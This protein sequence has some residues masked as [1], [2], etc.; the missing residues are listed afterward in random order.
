MK[1]KHAI[2]WQCNSFILESFFMDLVDYIVNE[3]CALKNDHEAQRMAAYMK[4]TM[5]FYGVRAPQR[6]TI[7]KDAVCRFPIESYDRYIAVITQLWKH[8]HREVKYVAIDIARAYP[9]YICAASLPFYKRMI[10]EGAWWDF[11]DDIAINLVGKALLHDP[12]ELW[13]ILDT[14]IDDTRLWVRRSALICQ[15]KWKKQTD[16]ERLFAYCLKTAYEPDFFMRKAIGWA[17]REYAKTA[18]D[19]VAVLV[20]NHKNQLSN[21]SRR[22]A[23]KHIG[24][25]LNKEKSMVK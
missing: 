5:P 25:V 19:E 24:G 4:T 18:S 20:E 2:C 17:L 11:V 15:N 14:W 23:L 10:E 13:P 21:L 22:E 9:A 7:S 16:A 8:T 12:Q 1:E 6:R 3:L